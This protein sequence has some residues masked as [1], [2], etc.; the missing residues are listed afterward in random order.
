MK[1]T[2]QESGGK[3]CEIFKFWSFLQSE[4]LNS[5]YTN[6]FSRSPTG[7][8]PPEP[9]WGTSVPSPPELHPPIKIPS[10]AIAHYSVPA[11]IG[12]PELL[13]AEWHLTF[14]GP[15]QWPPY[16]RGINPVNYNLKVRPTMQ[17]RLYMKIMRR[18]TTPAE[19]FAHDW[20]T[21]YRRF[22]W[23]DHGLCMPGQTFS[24]RAAN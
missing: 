21:R 2:G 20:T 7:D 19:L 6:C 5:V 15:D 4:S 22:H 17:Q 9:Y 16:S 18:A 24:T 3:L 12:R 14:S 23:V 10:A 8:S 1:H 11:Y 13:N